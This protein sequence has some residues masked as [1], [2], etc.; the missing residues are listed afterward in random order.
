MKV[1]ARMALM[2]LVS[3]G[4]GSSQ[5]VPPTPPPAA[6][7]VGRPRPVA[8]VP[9]G[10]ASGQFHTLP[11]A[12]SGEATVAILDTGIGL[13]LVSRALC[14]RIGCTIEGEFTGRRMSGQEVSVPLT[15]LERLE[16]GGVVRHD[17]VA[18]VLGGEGFYPEPQIE[19][20]V[21]LPFFHGQPFTIDGPG[22]VLVLES[23]ASLKEREVRG[24]TLPLR[25]E[26]HG[27]ALD[28]FV[29]VSLGG[30]A[31][32][33]MLLDTGSRVVILHPRYAPAA[34]VDLADPA[35]RRDSG[36]DETGQAYSRVYARAATPIAFR[37]APEQSR[38]DYEVMFQEIIHD[39]LIGTDL[40]ASFVMT[41]DLERSQLTVASDSPR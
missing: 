28:S 19:A 25:L 20:F 29:H 5:P 11:V 33:E 9:L 41:W 37:G 39:G 40:L 31:S 4:C 27:P 21:G 3:F 8:T 6:Q 32:A 30:E 14:E 7:P 13:A 17:V 26:E 38:L 10:R 16:V 23:P 15:T 2:C 24:R 12:V 1:T 36:S 35:L 22:Q 34:G 18:G